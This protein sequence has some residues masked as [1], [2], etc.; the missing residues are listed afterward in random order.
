MLR[1]S[2]HWFG[3]EASLAQVW[4]AIDLYEQNP[5]LYPPRMSE[6]ADENSGLIQ[7]DD[8][9]G[10]LFINGPLTAEESWLDSYF[11]ITSYPAIARG[12]IKLAEMYQQGE[13]HQIVHAY[14]TP[15]GDANGINGLTEVL[16]AAKQIA[17]DTVSYTGSTAFSA[18]YWL[19]TINDKLY[20]DKMAEVGSIG[21]ISTVMSRHR[22]LD[23]AGIDVKVIRS[24]KYKALLHPLE[25]LSEA[26]LAEVAKKGKELHQFFYE[27]IVEERPKLAS[28]PRESWAEGQTFFGQAAV[29]LGLADGPPISLNGLVQKLKNRNNA[30][31]SFS[32]RG[33]D[34]A[35]HIVFPT[36]AEQAAVASGADLA[37]VAHV[38]EEIPP[39]PEAALQADPEPE[40]APVA[41]LS[42]FLREELATARHEVEDLKIK[43]A[44]AEQRGQVEE[45]LAPIVAEATNRLQI[46]LRQ[47]PTNLQGLPASVLAEQYS[48][49][50]AQF[51]KSFPVGQR[52]LAETDASRVPVD[53]GEQRLFLVQ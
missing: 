8:G 14:S 26:G 46:A 13:I 12:A 23:E 45:L 7:V 24:G 42:A 37:A 33:T 51:E 32:A 19:A 21:V 48:A 4:R 3:D 15:G 31:Y 27:H 22:M 9:I 20:V 35:K 1:V 25:P 16:Q 29:D 6:D 2:D 44:L 43:L 36:P 53:A 10:Y 30:G 47:S 52:S 17:P 34:M 40:P 41:D 39:V 49:M 38:E 50:K 11:G 5:A 28:V 18:G